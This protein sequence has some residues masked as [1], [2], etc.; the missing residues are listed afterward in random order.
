M[1]YVVPEGM[2]SVMTH[3]AGILTLTIPAKRNW[4]ILLFLGFWIC[5]WAVGEVMAPVSFLSGKAPT[6]AIIFMIAWLGMWTVGG[7]FAIYAWLWQVAGKEIIQVSTSSISRRRALFRFGATKEFGLAHVR[8]LRIAP[9]QGFNPFD[10]TAAGS[11]WGISGGTI[12]FDY[13]AK[14]FRV[15]QGLDEAEAQ[16]IVRKIKEV[17][18]IPDA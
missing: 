8:N 3:E 4:F 14:T 9:P 2:R 10:F 13:G 5:G 16:S 7:A 12:A 18:R 1:P 11:F 15:G 17:V 6:E